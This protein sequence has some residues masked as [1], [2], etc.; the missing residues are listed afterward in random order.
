MSVPQLGRHTWAEL[1]DVLRDSIISGRLAPGE[2]LVEAELAET[3][4][5]S[6]GPVR[7]A[8]ADLAHTGLVEAVGKRGVIVVSLSPADVGE[9][10]ELRYALEA[11]AISR[12]CG[13]GPAVDLS[14]L[15]KCLARMEDAIKREARTEAVGADLE[16]HRTLCVLS[17]N[18]RLL[19]AWDAISDQVRLMIGMLMSKREPSVDSHIG[20]HRPIQDAIA[21]G[22][23]VAAER[24][25]RDHL[26]A[27]REV[28]VREI[29]P[30][31]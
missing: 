16:F 5:V 21:D 13:L 26:D 3:Y 12:L 18:G 19:A 30:V 10:F 24:H 31:D 27:I 28:L 22:D 11:A 8:L 25:L 23:S 6:R 2:R 1:A 20:D 14:P 7:T 15:E 9:V 4:G 29:S 17:G